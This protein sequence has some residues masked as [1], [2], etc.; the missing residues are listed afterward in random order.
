[1]SLRIEDLSFSWPGQP[2]P[3][4]K[5]PELHV[6]S[7]EKVFLQGASGSGKTTLLGLL[8]GVLLPQRGQI[9]VLDTPLHKLSAPERDR[10]RADHIGFIFQM[11]NLLPYLSVMGNVLLPLRFSREKQKRLQREAE[12][13][14]QRLLSS[15]GLDSV[16]DRQVQDLSV[17]QQQRVAAARALIGAPE[18]IIADEPTSALDA[19]S[20]EAFLE[21]LFTEISR[22][23]STLIY[24]SHDPG[25]ASV[26]DRNLSMHTFHSDLQK[27]PSS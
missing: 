6:K 23:R 5:C 19:D 4:L 26:F 1:M 24:V 10:F 15:L 22:S 3:L 25:I 20:R 16:S 21:L 17:G 2:E 11:F 12:E 14:A 13:E 9:F 27:D 8:G 7:G 18:L